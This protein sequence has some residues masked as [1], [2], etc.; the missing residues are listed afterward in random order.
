MKIVV[1]FL[2]WIITLFTLLV[3]FSYKFTMWLNPNSLSYNDD[4]YFYTLFPTLLNVLLL[5]FIFK[6]GTKEPLLM[7]TILF[8]LIINIIVFCFYIAFQFVTW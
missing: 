3:Q 5:V 8:L 2:S 1:L 4:R 7:R 6:S